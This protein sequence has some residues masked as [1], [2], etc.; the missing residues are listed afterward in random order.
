VQNKEIPVEWK[1]AQNQSQPPLGQL[2]HGKTISWFMVAFKGKKW[3]Q[4]R[5]NPFFID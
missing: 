2:R 3:K 1:R 5:D 4:K